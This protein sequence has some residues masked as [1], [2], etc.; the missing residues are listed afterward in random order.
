MRQHRLLKLGKVLTTRLRI[1][2]D[3]F[4][5]KILVIQEGM[6]AYKEEYEEYLA[7]NVEQMS[8]VSQDENNQK[9]A[10]SQKTNNQKWAYIQ[11]L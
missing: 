8:Q 7:E 6:E 2:K 5:V 10:S 3:Y 1:T 9:K 4:T 11:L